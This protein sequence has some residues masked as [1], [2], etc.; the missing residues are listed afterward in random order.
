MK[1]ISY[2]KKRK[3][4]KVSLILCSPRKIVV[5]S[6]LGPMTCLA[7]SSYPS[8]GARYVFCEKDLNPIRKWLVA[9]I[10]FMPLLTP[11]SMPCQTSHHC[12]F[13]ISQLSRTDN[14]FTSLV[15]PVGIKLSHQ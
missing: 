1:K 14:Y 8:N 9:S 7:T 5:C 10:M 11:V 15:E 3:K 4:K 6:P 12:G 13:Q 2:K